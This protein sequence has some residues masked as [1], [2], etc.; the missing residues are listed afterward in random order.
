LSAGATANWWEAGVW[1]ITAASLGFMLNR[2]GWL[3][4]DE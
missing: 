2:L 1:A 3:G 4:D